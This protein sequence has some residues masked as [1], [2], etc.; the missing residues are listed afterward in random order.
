MN[1]KTSENLVQAT[2]IHKSL[3]R[4]LT[5]TDYSKSKSIVPVIGA[6]TRAQFSESWDALQ[7]RLSPADIARVEE[8]IPASA[9]AGIRYD[10]HQMRK[11]DSEL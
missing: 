6:R 1:H 11:L 3:K 8:A 2:T 5:Q 4:I 9:I 7:I 10:K